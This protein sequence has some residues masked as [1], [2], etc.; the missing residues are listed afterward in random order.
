MLPQP[1]TDQWEWQ[2][3][4]RCRT[5]S[6]VTFFPPQGTRGRELHRIERAAKALCAQCPVQQECRAHALEVG[7]P[8]G[9]W[10]GMTA[11][12]RFVHTFGTAAASE[13]QQP[14]PEP[15]HAIGP[16]RRQYIKRPNPVAEPNG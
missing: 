4:G 16:P 7:E 3:E 5:E 6:S 9:I 15:T 14:S 2:L 8:Y 11:R 13:E 10:G 12:E 1:Q